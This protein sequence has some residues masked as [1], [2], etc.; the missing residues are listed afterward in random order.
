MMPALLTST[1]LAA[2]LWPPA[3]SGAPDARSS[4]GE[5]RPLPVLWSR[6]ETGAAA[7][8]MA[9]HAAA[10]QEAAPK[11]LL[12][13]S[14]RAI[15]YQISRLSNDELARVER[16]PGDPKY[17]PI[18]Y[19]L[20]TRRGMAKGLRDEALGALAKLEGVT[21]AEVLLRGLARLKSV[22]DQ[23]TADQLLEAL[24]AQP[25]DA[26]RGQREAFAKAAAGDQPFVRSAGYG[27]LMLVDGD[28]GQAWQTAQK[29]GHLADLLRAVP[30]LTKADDL[31]AKLFTPISTLLG[32]TPESDARG[33]AVAALGYTRPDAATFALLARELDP[34]R[35]SDPAVRAAAVASLQRIPPSAWP[36]ASVEPLARAVVA[37]LRETPADRRT[38]P[39]AVHAVQLGE[40]LAAALPDASKR[41][42]L[43][44]LRGLGVRIVT[45][46]TLPEQLLYDLKWFVVEAG[47]P[48]QIV[49]V[50]SDTMPHNVVVGQPGSVRDIGLAGATVLPTSDPNAKA[51]VPDS[52]L[53]LASTRLVNGG[54]TERLNFTAPEKAGE[55]NFL[56]SFPGHWLRM[57]GVMVVV[58]DLDAFE[59]KPVEP[60][61]PL[62]GQPMGAHKR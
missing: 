51:Y 3:G 24:F 45:I 55:Y 25:G 60:K 38:E 43:R 46:D 22:E 16:Q 57:Y 40:Q 30:R 18:Y 9:G 33:A 32:G 13:Q 42:V 54:E 49:L 14:P 41:A 1:V 27:G 31:R 6:A 59:A 15:E 39:D 52:P 5:R 2:M 20:L 4:H 7:A 58:P 17:V 29:D 47:K 44:D 35:G 26:L 8:H 19:A 53:V 21:P 56:C 62:T 50:N 48:V 37:M 10:A 61:D 23:P 34:A 12:D 11:I 36:A 28:P